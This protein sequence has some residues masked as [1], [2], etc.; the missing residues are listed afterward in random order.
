MQGYYILNK[1]R[2]FIEFNNVMIYSD[3]DDTILYD[4]IIQCHTLTV[5]ICTWYIKDSE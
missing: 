1:Y 3:S 4:W 2:I 5:P